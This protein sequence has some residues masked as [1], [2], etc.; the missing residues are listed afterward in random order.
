MT[1]F[2]VPQDIE[3]TAIRHVDVEHHQIPMPAPQ[4]IQGLA[5]CSGLGNGVKRAVLLQIMAE[6]RT[7][8]GMIIG[9]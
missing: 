1:G 9:N 5:A 4:L 3:S 7:D 2:D 8:H 6:A